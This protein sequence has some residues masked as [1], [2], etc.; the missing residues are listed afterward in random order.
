MPNDNSGQ[1]ADHDGFEDPTLVVRMLEPNSQSDSVAGEREV[2]DHARASFGDDRMSL[3]EMAAVVLRER[4][5]ILAA[6]MLTSTALIVATVLDRPSW[7]TTVSFMP[8]GTVDANR[9]RLQGLAGQFGINIGTAETGQSPQFYAELIRS[10][11]ILGAVASREYEVADTVGLTASGEV[12]RGHLAAL[13]GIEASNADERREKTVTWLRDD[14]VQLTTNDE[15]SLVELQITVGWPTLAEDIADQII[16]AVNEFNLERRQSKA[17]EERRF[18]EARLQTAKLEL[19]AAEDSLEA[20]LQSNRAFQNSPELS[21]EHDRL[22]RQVQMRQELFTSLTQAYEQAR[23]EEVRTTPV[24]TVVDQA[25][26]PA[27]PDDEQFI[28]KAV[29]GAIFGL[30]GGVALA[31]IREYLRRQEREDPEH[32]TLLRRLWREAKSDFLKFLPASGSVRSRD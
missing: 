28:F 12:R 30:M 22:F 3:I 5:L 8:Q 31:F 25:A 14:V 21:F 20:F 16:Q 11:T 17:A 10:R 26:A 24:I 7:T 9:S 32:Y 13:V 1:E 2:S 19:K 29:L 15:T 27:S 18:V 4:R 23:I 6:V